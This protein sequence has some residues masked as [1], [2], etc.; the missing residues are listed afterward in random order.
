MYTKAQSRV[1]CLQWTFRTSLVS[2]S[3]QGSIKVGIFATPHWLLTPS[4]IMTRFQWTVFNLSA[5][6]F[7]KNE[8]PTHETIKKEEIHLLT[9][10]DCR[11]LISRLCLTGDRYCVL[12]LEMNATIWFIVAESGNRLLSIPL[13]SFILHSHRSDYRTKFM[14]SYLCCPSTSG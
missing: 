10:S 12:S 2:S 3:N 7:R 9:I 5:T 4:P 13:N 14:L 6:I 1:L 11:S 8:N